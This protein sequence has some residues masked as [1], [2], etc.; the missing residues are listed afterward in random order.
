MED[1]LFPVIIL[2]I[3]AVSSIISAAAKGKKSEA[4]KKAFQQHTAARAAAAAKPASMATMLPQRPVAQPQFK[5]SEPTVHAH[6][7]PDC[8]THDAPGSLG[9]SS[10][11]GKDP[12][13]EDQ[14]TAR[15][16]VQDETETA[17][18]LTL[19]W[20]GE[21]LVKSFIMQEVLTRP[22]QRRAAR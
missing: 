11:E 21:S 15:R 22:A 1:S 2:I 18:S 13:H 3:G 7:D 19:D 6:L 14:L 12:C 20:T 9:V 4:A 16:P 10:S 17:P 5:V 8:E